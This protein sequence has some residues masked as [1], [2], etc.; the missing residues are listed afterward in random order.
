MGTITLS[1][2][3]QRRLQILTRSASGELSI[4][5]AAQL[6]GVT[7]RQA[8]RLLRR[9]HDEG[10]ASLIHG[11]CTRAPSNKTLVD[12]RDRIKTLAGPGGAY[13]DFNTTH[14]CELLAEREHIQIGRSTLD[15]LLREEGLRRSKHT[16][17]R[18]FRRR[19]R[20]PREGELLQIDA[21]PHNWLEGRGPRMCLMGAIDDATGKILH[22]RFWP[23]ETLD[24]YLTLFQEVGS[25]YGLPVSFYHDKHTILRSPKAR[26]IEDE[27]RGTEPMSQA[28]QVLKL[29]GVEGIT[30]HSPQAKGR[31][32]RMWRTLQ[33]RLRKEMRL[34]GVTTQQEANAFAA[35]FAPR[36]NARFAVAPADPEP[37]WVKLEPGTDLAY[38]FARREPRTVKADHTLS[39]MG[40]TLH[41]IRRR[42]EPSLAGKIVQV[43]TDPHGEVF[44]YYGKSRLTYKPLAAA[45]TA[46]RPEQQ[47]RESASAARAQPAEDETR[48]P[49]SAPPGAAPTVKKTDNAGRRAWLYAGT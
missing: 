2:K 27:L 41:I 35:E 34:A 42:G 16:R 4:S 1:E 40:A 8:C 5:Q 24:G 44:L 19:E 3:Q 38:Y 7:E 12:T 36:F 23:T 37:A 20:F 47:T 28:Q 49:V 30:A 45:Q 21:S 6:L 25:V 14:L 46:A 11:N 29:L 39:W 26:T 13:H 33:D 15:R 18:V 31:V 32:E 22:L 17:R 43:H 10:A 48:R 9:L